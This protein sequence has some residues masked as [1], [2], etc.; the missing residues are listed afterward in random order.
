MRAI[1]R[2]E[3]FSK[4]LHNGQDQLKNL[5]FDRYPVLK[6]DDYCNLDKV[7]EQNFD[8]DYVWLVDKN[9]RV[10]DS[11]PWWFKPRAID[12]VQIHEFP[13]VYKESRKVKSWDKVRLVPTKK[14]DTEPR[15]HIHICGE[16]DVYKGND[17][18]DAFYI[19]S[20]QEDIDKLSQKVPHLQTVE[21]WYEAQAKSYTGMFWVVWEDIDVRDTFKFSYKPDEWSHDN[22]HVFGN[23]DIDTLDG[24]ALFPK[25]YKITDKE[26][27]H[28]FY[29]N[30]KE[31]RIMAST[32]KPYN[33]F[34][35]NSYKEYEYALEKSETDLFWGV[36]DDI[37]ITDD[38]VFNF[39]IDHHNQALKNKNH[40]W[41]NNNKYNGLVLFSKN[42]IVSNKEIEYRFIADRIEH[43]SVVSKPKPFNVFS[44]NNYKDY[45]DALDR[46]ETQ[47]FLGVPS[48]VIVNDFDINAYFYDA[49]ELDTGT[50][51]L[52]LNGENFD[53]VVLFSKGN[54]VTEKE[55][56]HRFYTNKK[57]HNIVVSN[58][59][60]YEKFVI[61]NYN[62]YL[63]ALKETKS[64]MFWGIPSDVDVCED[65][66]F[67]LY[68]S[69]HNKFDREIN[70][71]FLNNEFYDGVVL[72][73]K[74]SLATEKEVEARFYVNKKEWKTVASNPKKYEKFT[75]S[76]Y[77]DYLRAREQSKTEMFYM[78]YDDIVVVDD[79][80]FD[81][82]ITHHNQYE[83]KINHV[84]KNGNFYDGIALTTKSILLT[85]HEIDYRFLAIKKEYEQVA[86]VADGFDIVFI[87]NGEANAEQNYQTLLKAYPNAKRVDKVKGIHQAHIAA[88]KLVN[89]KMF[90]VVDGDAEILEDFEFDHQ[91]AHYD[92][93]GYKTVF[94]W[95]S[96]NPVN[97]LIYGYGGVK[98][99]PTQLTIDMD[100]ETAD[101][102][103]SISRNFKGINRMSNVTA[104]NTD[105]FSA[106]R[107]GFRECAKLAS[108]A[109]DRQ[110]DDETTFRLKAWCS[111]GFDKPFG[112]ETIAGAYEGA[113]YGLAFKNN[114]DALRKINDFK[115]L[116]DKFK[117]TFDP[118]I[119]EYDIDFLDESE[120]DLLIKFNP[121]AKSIFTQIE[122]K[123]GNNY[124]YS[125]GSVKMI[126]DNVGEIYFDS[127]GVKISKAYADA[128]II[129]DL[130]TALKALA[131][132]VDTLELYKAGDLIV[133]GDVELAQDF[134]ADLRKKIEA[135]VQTGI[136]LY[137]IELNEFLNETAHLNLSL[138]IE[139]VGN[140]SI[141]GTG[142]KESAET[143]ETNIKLVEDDWK[144][145]LAGELTIIELIQ[146][147]MAS[148]TG[149][150]LQVIELNQ[151]FH[152][153]ET[154]R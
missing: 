126:I 56:E 88:A 65:F 129:V 113:K 5:I 60:A 109:I 54:P 83:R 22:V 13:Y 99:L 72:F 142:I 1:D 116:N 141:N 44:I 38:N 66:D 6:I 32:P 41:L 34:P 57:E 16:Y 17:K 52:F 68:F 144:Q 91:I 145:L 86:S 75:I 111:R 48:D 98:L 127:K 125:A 146:E 12:E 11:F 122:K 152:Y 93:D 21:N 131:G 107:S 40:V 80:K 58:P 153:R 50:T 140:I 81:L 7:Y 123:L 147:Q 9:I 89:T 62:D 102:T 151:L 110:V 8:S 20:N 33:K 90:W 150:I 149:D 148:Y 117:N 18:F 120:E 95:R 64:D 4:P 76:N 87:S 119:T 24:V 96:L 15:Q 61:N 115:W 132:E 49:D 154:H 106:W 104:F 94:V 105:A 25:N 73:S 27:E 143:L 31:V 43:D 133:E 47:M 69:H 82:Y 14:V 36:P 108:K 114:K 30:K 70:H 101:M 130:K 35:I 135:G 92:I 53:G 134:F 78:I 85:K 97:D 3:K 59:R 136:S 138:E 2:F 124:K 67:D 55:V 74:K 71:V 23:G 37:E 63:S 128:E 139:D 29:I 118:D 42:S 19:G 28:R 112:A 10:Y 77:D 45:L 51:H 39:Y 121:V 26:L 79:F 103:T 100:V 46:T 137:I 84:W